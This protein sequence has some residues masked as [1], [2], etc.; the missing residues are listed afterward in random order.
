MS[1]VVFVSWSLV[2]LCLWFRYP[3]SGV[4]VGCVNAEAMKRCVRFYVFI[5]IYNSLHVSSTSC[6]SSGE[7]NCIN[8][9]FGNSHSMLVAAVHPGH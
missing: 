9:A 8:I 5:S 4:G 2:D 3:V 6:S 1:W 7:T